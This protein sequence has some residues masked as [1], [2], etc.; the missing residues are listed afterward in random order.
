MDQPPKKR[1]LFIIPTLEGGGAERVLI[2]LLR[3]TDYNKYSIHIAVVSLFGIY[4]NQVPESVKVIPLFKNDLLV[5]SLSWLQKKTGFSL[6]FRWVVNYKLTASYDV[7]ISFIDSNFTELLFFV[8]NVKKRIAWVHS[9]YKTNIQFARFYQ[10]EAYRQ[11]LIKDRYSRLDQL[12]FVSDD[13]RQEFTEVFGGFPDM[14]VIYNLLD[15]EGVKRSAD[16]PCEEK[17]DEFLFLSM[18]SL[19]PVKGF[20]R[21][22]RAASILKFKEIH[23]RLLIL[24]EGPE[25]DRLSSQITKAGLEKIVILKGYIANPYPLLKRCDVFV[26]SSVSEALPTA[27]CEAMILGKPILVTNSSGCR[28]ITG[29]GDFGLMAEQDDNDLSAKME[30]FIVEPGLKEL[31]AEKAVQRSAIFNDDKILEQYYN[32]FDN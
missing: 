1:I 20:D 11:K 24:G 15:T 3:K 30:R 9:S 22:I 26:M 16:E 25:Y 6:I 31:Y 12:I 23:F 18:G 29:Y 10:N 21:L 32:I 19:W 14:K 2:N 4:S 5:R 13:A 7:G 27:L 17:S 8:E 28:E